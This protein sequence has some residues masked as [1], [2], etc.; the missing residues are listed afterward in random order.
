M[1]KFVIEE[2]FSGMFS[3]V[4]DLLGYRNSV[5][6]SVKPIR[7]DIKIFG[8]VRTVELIDVNSIEIP[9][10]I[11]KGLSYLELIQENEILFVKGSD[12][13]AYFGELMTRLSKR[14][15]LQA[16]V[17]CGFSRDSSFIVNS[18]FN[19]FSSGFLPSDIKSR[20]QVKSVDEVVTINN[21]EVNSGDYIFGDN[22]GIVVIPKKIENI[23]FEKIKSTIA[24]EKLIVEK[25][26]S[27]F[28]V[29]EIL[30]SHKSF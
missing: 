5:I 2:L 13:Y 12:Q 18:G 9:E 26:D 22:D 28:S 3:D 6:S 7:S 25:I 21:V 1:N 17:I 27:G 30:K 16:A 24:D 15:G 11:E 8:K 19:F 23:V 10:N 14:Q 4:L 20:G 29:G